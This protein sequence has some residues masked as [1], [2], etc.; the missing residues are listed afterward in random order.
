M[1]KIVHFGVCT[2]DGCKLCAAYELWNSRLYKPP[3]ENEITRTEVQSGN[4]GEIR[5]VSKPKLTFSDLARE[6]KR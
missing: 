1:S 3:V 4:E 2:G 5:R 6:R